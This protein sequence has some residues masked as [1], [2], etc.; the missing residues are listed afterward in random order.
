MLPGFIAFFALEILNFKR[1]ALEFEQIELA[2]ILLGIP[3]FTGKLLFRFLIPVIYAECLI[4]I[5][6][7]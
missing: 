4:Q 2:Q 6:L 7:P 1:V 3:L 5:T